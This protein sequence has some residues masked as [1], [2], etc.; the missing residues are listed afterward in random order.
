MSEAPATALDHR[1]DELAAVGW[2]LEPVPAYERH[3][4]LRDE[5]A[6]LLDG[7]LVRVAR[8]TGALDVAIGDA[9]ASLSIGDRALRLGFSSVGDYARERLGIPASTAQKMARLARGL[10]ERP[11]LR[12]AVWRGEV[13]ARKAETVLP[14]ARGDSEAPWVA[15]ATVETVRALAVGVREA[16][17][18]AE[19][20]EDEPWERISFPISQETRVALDEVLAVAGKLLGATALRWQRLE[21]ICS[22]FL[23]AHPLDP[24]EGAMAPTPSHAGEVGRG[25]GDDPA[26][27]SDGLEEVK[28]WLEEETSSWSFLEVVPPLPAH[29][30]SEA[31]GSSEP[32]ALDAELRRLARMRERWDELF[33][34]LAM[35]LRSCGLW[36][37][38]QF[39][40][41][42]HYCEERLG[43]GGRAVSQRIALCKRLYDLPALRTAMREGRLSYEKARLV[44]RR[45]DEWTEAEWIERAERLPCVALAR[46][47]D[48][49]EEVQMCAEGEL[50][51]RL[52]AR[53]SALLD[54]ALRAARASSGGRLSPDEC[55][56]RVARHFTETWEPQLRARST[57]QQRVLARDQGVCQVPGCSRAALHVHHV[58]YR[59]RGG[60]D[61]P[62]NLTSLCA[63]HHL[64][65]VHRGWLRVS[66]RAPQG[67]RWSFP[68]VASAGMG[69][70]A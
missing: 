21:A 41:F 47:V 58:V 40:S 4:L 56:R 23:A 70:V 13:T 31:D 33:G 50:R 59:S 34:H 60:G 20:D 46:E 39:V 14:V 18:G 5:C 12:A 22:E 6:T 17:A 29:G 61:E 53:V 67:L 32:A 65:G 16:L 51:L 48:A 38:M 7:L 52:P 28:A 54:D 55:L 27:V 10:R 63:A 11:L 42:A 68:A 66:G 2:T 25:E 36:R 1:L 62:G 69:C 30:L 15:R 3:G 44:A 24:R 45:A 57:V 43:V 37:D 8:G 64:H 35:L 26:V 9:L 19:L 49:H